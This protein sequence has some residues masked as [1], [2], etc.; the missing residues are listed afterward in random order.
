MSTL[1]QKITACPPDA[2]AGIRRGIEKEGLRVLPTGGLAL[3]PHPLALGSA[4]THPLITTDYSESQLELIT[5]AH[6]GVQ[7]CLDE[8][9][10]VHQFVHHT[11]KDG[12]G[13][14]LWASSM[15]CGLPTD[16]TIP[17]ARYGSSNIGRA[18][19]VYR[20]GL[21]HRYGRRMQT[22]S[23]IHY[24]WSI[25]GVTSE[26]YFSLIRNF[27]RHAFVLLYLF[28]ASPALCP[29]FVEG[30]EHRLQRME[31]GSALYLPHAT[32]LRMGRLGY[33]SDAQATLAVSYNG[34][35]GYANSLHEALT[36]PYPAYEALGIRNPGGDYNQLGTSLL[37]I[38]NEFYGTIR[39]KRT[40]RTGERPLHALRERGVEYVE[41]RLMD[42][43]PFV[44]VGITAPTMRLLD[45]F[46]LHCL[47]SDSP[48]DTPQE[49]TELK[50]NQHLTAE[51]GREPGLCLVRNGQNVA[52]VDWAAQVLQECA[53][54]AAALDASHHSTDYSAALA[55]A[56]ATLA[57]PVQTPSARVLEQMAREHGNNFTSFSTH[58]SAQARD[59][60]L[61][62][63]WSDA[64]HARFTAMAEESVAAQKAIEAADALPFE[65]WR[66]HYMAAQG[67]G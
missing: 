50:R 24:N 12:G 28:G 18:K 45:V 61:D 41:V 53:P 46:L 47:L 42:L 30:R 4:L 17:L 25:P 67:L 14:L 59:A 8:L 37:Q 40:V 36:K 2:L 63:P 29:C 16:E 1:Q 39:P 6:K 33:Q 9:T 54:L 22:I 35:T 5:G 31:G 15:P 51:R 38:E 26:E 44:P 27:R 3:T 34:L 62:L 58:Q 64:Q 7:Q 19:S 20:M 13:E 32:S 56:R 23:G 52:L 21:G 57:N 55:S 10:E 49:I 48:P 65:E 11:L 43:D 66:Q 60:L